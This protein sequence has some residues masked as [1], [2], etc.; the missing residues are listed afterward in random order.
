MLAPDVFRLV[1]ILIADVRVL[2]TNHGRT[3]SLE[4]ACSS[5]TTCSSPAAGTKVLSLRK[6][7]GTV[8]LQC[9]VIRLGAPWC[10]LLRWKN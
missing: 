6:S 9:L 10:C 3:A 1:K 8:T 2:L 5:C 7:G 4:A